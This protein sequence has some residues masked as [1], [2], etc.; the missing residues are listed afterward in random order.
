MYWVRHNELSQ[1]YAK[2]SHSDKK[3]QHC[4]QCEV[5]IRGEANLDRVAIMSDTLNQMPQELATEYRTKLLPAYIV[6]GGKASSETELDPDWYYQQV[7]Q[8]KAAGNVPTS[9]PAST[10]DFLKAYRELSQQTRLKAQDE[11]PQTTIKIINSLTACGDTPVIIKAA[12]AIEDGGAE[13]Y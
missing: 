11:S 6:L 8:W 12:C 10:R 4:D 7:S 3:N 13:C 9:S 2:Y 1:Q 5:R